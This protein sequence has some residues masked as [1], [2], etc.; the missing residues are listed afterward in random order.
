M[1]IAAPATA[2]AVTVPRF[3]GGISFTGGTGR[4]S[5]FAATAT[6]TVSGAPEGYATLDEAV[7]ALTIATVGAAVGAAGVFERDGRFYGRELKN[8]LT[9][10]SGT[11]WT[12]PWRLEQHP[13]DKELLDGSVGGVTTRVKS[14]QAVVD[15]AQRVLVTDLPIA[16]KR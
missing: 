9:F 8:S 15:G 11:S 2:S 1:Q 7:D 10:A 3:T 4:F 6:G 13:Q 12:G 14:L 16:T 5:A